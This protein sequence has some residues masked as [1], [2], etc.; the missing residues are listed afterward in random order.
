MAG[1]RGGARLRRRA[2]VQARPRLGEDLELASVRDHPAGAG[3]R[4]PQALADLELHRI[5]LEGAYWGIAGSADDYPAPSTPAYSRRFVRDF[6]APIRIDLDVF[7]EG[8]R[9]VLENHGYLM[10]ETAIQSHLGA[11]DPQPAPLNVPFPDWMDES[12]AAEAL[13]ESAT[14]KLFARGWF[15][16]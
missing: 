10:A 4:G 3:D 16:R 2:D 15:H 5:Q 6:I 8:E 7:S 12:K 13:R 9:A 14:T 11:L 1:P